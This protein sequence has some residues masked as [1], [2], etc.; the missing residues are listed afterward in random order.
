LFLG[1]SAWFLLQLARQR[2]AAVQTVVRQDLAA[3]LLQPSKTAN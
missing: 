1:S 3:A 2:A